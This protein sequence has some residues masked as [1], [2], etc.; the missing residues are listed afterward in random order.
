MAWSAGAAEGKHAD[1]GLLLND[2]VVSGAVSGEFSRGLWEQEGPAS[3]KSIDIRVG[4]RRLY[5]LI[6][7]CR[8]LD[9]GK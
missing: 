6:Q 4:A 1:Q 3:G 5:P 8:L 7:G 9:G 2:P